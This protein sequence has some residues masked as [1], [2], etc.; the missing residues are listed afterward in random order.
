MKTTYLYVVAVL[1]ALLSACNLDYPSYTSM[2]EKASIASPTDVQRMSNALYGMLRTRSNGAYNVYTDL[3]TEDFVATTSYGNAYRGAVEWQVRTAD[4]GD[5]ESI[6]RNYYFLIANANRLINEHGRVDYTTKADTLIKQEALGTAYTMRALAYHYLVSRFALPYYSDK[7]GGTL[8]KD[9]LGVPLEL[10]VDLM[11][12][13]PRAT[14]EQVYAQINADLDSATL[15]MT[16]L[17]DAAYATATYKNSPSRFNLDAVNALRARV[18]LYQGQWGQALEAAEAVI[19]TGKY[20]LSTTA[21]EL[22]KLWANDQGTEIIT[23]LFISD[24]ETPNG[25]GSYLAFSQLYRN[26][27]L[28]YTST[29]LPTVKAMELYEDTDYRFPAYYSEEYLIFESS[30]K[31]GFYSFAKFPRTTEFVATGNTAHSPI[32][33]RSGETY[34]NAAEAALRLGDEAKAQTYLNALR[35]SRGLTATTA[36][37]TTLLAELQQERRKELMGEGH[38]LVDKKRWHQGVDRASM[39]GQKTSDYEPVLEHALNQA[40]AAGDPRF[41]WPIPAAEISQNPKMVQNAGY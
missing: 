19:N 33:F 23:H 18:A 38:N 24:S 34:L 11:K 29:F 26:R 22:K 14:L 13:L 37:G 30:I 35:V 41:V 4:D 27:Y 28:L 9:S 2:E 32:V 25:H 17:R 7:D 10:D 6:W 3:S 1:T 36:T 15:Y 31:V 39:G 8:Y 40:Y 5:L 12:R 20:P 16:A 21:E